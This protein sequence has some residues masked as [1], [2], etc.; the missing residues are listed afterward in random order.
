MPSRRSSKK[1]RFLLADI[2]S[3]L[4]HKVRYVDTKLEHICP[5]NPSPE[6]YQD[7]GEGANDIVDRLGCARKA[8]EGGKAD[9]VA[10][11]HSERASGFDTHP[12]KTKSVSRKRVL[13]GAR[14]RAS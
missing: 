3:K 5:Y 7:F 9:D 6:W 2:E 12:A 10:G 8:L 4:G 13:H 14:Q 11:N 1:I